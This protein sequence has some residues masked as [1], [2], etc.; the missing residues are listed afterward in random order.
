MV[1]ILYSTNCPRCMVLE[2]KLNNAGINYS[3]NDNVEEMLALGFMEAPI[4]MVDGKA[5]NF[6]EANDWIG[7]QQHGN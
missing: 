7:E 4:L 1:V 3:I 2:K 6:K 5:M